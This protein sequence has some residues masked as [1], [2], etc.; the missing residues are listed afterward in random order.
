MGKV[1]FSMRG[2]AI[3]MAIIAVLFCCAPALYCS[4]P[5][6]PG[7]APTPETPSAGS[8]TLQQLP[9][10]PS[11]GP[12]ALQPTPEAPPV[13]PQPL[14]PPPAPVSMPAR[15]APDFT[16]SLSLHYMGI[17]G[18]SSVKT[19][20]SSGF[21]RLDWPMDF[22]LAGGSFRAVFRDI[23]ELGI[24]LQ[25][26]SQTESLH[27]MEDYDVLDDP[28]YGY[29]AHDGVDIYSK[30]ETLSKASIMTMDLRVFPLASRY[31][32]VGFFAGYEN[33][34]MSYNTFNVQQTGYGPW[35]PLFTVN[36]AGPTSTYSLDSEFFSL[37]LTWRL[38]AGDR[39]SLTV[40]TAY[41][42]HAKVTD[43][44]DHLRRYRESRVTSD[45][46]GNMISMNAKFSLT[47]RWFVSSSCSRVR[48]STDGTQDQFWYGNDPATAT[49]DTGTTINGIDAEIEQDYFKVGIALGCAL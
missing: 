10:T 32:A 45:G 43:I 36:V 38:K 30:S 22:E 47:P 17:N 24:S 28:H 35:A 42:P 44:D 9:E 8:Q 21:S 40:D 1:A 31:A 29:A 19:M 20:F 13:S 7:P 16:Y 11:A 4:G 48:I 15:T 41:I 49:D 33:Q 39:A 26:S 12:P 46:T 25:A 2:M 18:T 5:G 27:D 14:K 37:G 6:D 3:V 34:D 23:V